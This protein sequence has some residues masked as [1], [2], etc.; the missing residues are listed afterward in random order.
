MV[1]RDAMVLRPDG[2]SVFVVD[3]DQKAQQITVTTGIGAGELIEVF[4]NLKSGDNVIV[5]GNERIRPG[6]SVA[7]MEG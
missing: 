4:G 5:R 1:P 2:I 6:Q 3:A 7:I